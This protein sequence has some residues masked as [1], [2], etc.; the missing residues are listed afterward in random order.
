MVLLL[1]EKPLTLFE[2]MVARSV[3]VVRVRPRLGLAREATAQGHKC[4][5]KD[6]R[7]I[8]WATLLEIFDKVLFAERGKRGV[9]PAEVEGE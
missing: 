6:R 7:T 4:V 2:K 8:P 5:D 3:G 1:V 9:L